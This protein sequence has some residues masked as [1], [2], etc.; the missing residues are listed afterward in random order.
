MHSDIF[1][2]VGI[3]LDL[4][5]KKEIL[6]I[7]R[8]YFM[9]HVRLDEK[10]CTRFERRWPIFNTAIKGTLFLRSIMYQKMR[11]CKKVNYV[12]NKDSCVFGQNT[13]FEFTCV[14]RDPYFVSQSKSVVELQYIC[15]EVSRICRT[16]VS[17]EIFLYT[18]QFQFHISWIKYFLL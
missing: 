11:F 5:T 16:I 17:R 2:T 18:R 6:I 3:V 15:W 12:C 1:H 10:F 7:R 14:I 9:T 4:F 8:L 13:H